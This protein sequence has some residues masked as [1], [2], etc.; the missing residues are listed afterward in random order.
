[1]TEYEKLI[2]KAQKLLRWDGRLAKNAEKMRQ[3]SQAD[4]LPRRLGNTLLNTG[5]LGFDG[6]LQVPASWSSNR[7]SY[8]AEQELHATVTNITCAP[9]YEKA[10]G[11]EPVVELFES[12]S[13]RGIR[14]F[15]S[16]PDGRLIDNVGLAQQIVAAEA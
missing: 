12:P 16:L 2:P 4:S 15:L 5:R 10:V 7:F 11:E 3:S 6:L 13:Q 8:A 14:L 9:S 1:M